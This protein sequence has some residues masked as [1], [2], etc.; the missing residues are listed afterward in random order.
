M[1]TEEKKVAK[2]LIDVFDAVA[3]E[4]SDV[5]LIISEPDIRSR[6]KELEANTYF[7][8]LK[9]LVQQDFNSSNNN[10]TMNRSVTICK[11]DIENIRA[12]FNL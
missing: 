10:V 7:T 3:E 8:I 1:N 11:N 12:K 5:P 2:A 4:R 6:V 9:K